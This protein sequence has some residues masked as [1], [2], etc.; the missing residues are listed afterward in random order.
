MVAQFCLDF[1]YYFWF[2]A[3]K[4]YVLSVN[5]NVKYFMQNFG[6]KTVCVLLKIIPLKQS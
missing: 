2:M 1:E 6:F 4:K 5:K 3:K